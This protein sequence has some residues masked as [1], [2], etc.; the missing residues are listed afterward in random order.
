MYV[1]IILLR[2]AVAKYYTTLFTVLFA[3]ST[4]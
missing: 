1:I 4:I 3:S 2:A